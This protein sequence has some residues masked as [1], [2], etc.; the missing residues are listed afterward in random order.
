MET[1]SSDTAQVS[2][3]HT[4]ATSTI[5]ALRPLPTEVSLEGNVHLWDILQQYERDYGR[6]QTTPIPGE[7]EMIDASKERTARRQPPGSVSELDVQR[8]VDVY[9]TKFHGQ[10][11]LLHRPSFR[12]E[13]EPQFLVLSMVMISLWI[14]GDSTAQNAAV[15]IHERFLVLLQEQKVRTLQSRSTL[16]SRLNRDRTNGTRRNQH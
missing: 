1:D 2:N 12:P 7:V 9:F 4:S 14:S 6:L 11:P 8:H 10:W 5:D 3:Q 15:R 13:T 16:A